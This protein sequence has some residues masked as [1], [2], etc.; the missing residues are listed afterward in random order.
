MELK[1]IEFR[2][3]LFKGVLLGVREYDFESEDVIEKDIVIYL[4]MV[5]FIVTLIYNK[6]E[7]EGDMYKGEE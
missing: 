1:R 3:G 7:Y 4:G 5:Q 2:V 6:K